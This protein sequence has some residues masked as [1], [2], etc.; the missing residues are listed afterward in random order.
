MKS[1]QLLGYLG[2]LPFITCLYLSIIT[3]E[4]VIAAQQAFI[5]YSAIIL[6]FIAGSIWRED[7]NNTDLKQRIISNIFS[8][9]AFVTLLIERDIALIILAFSFLMLFFYE[10]NLA[11]LNKEKHREVEYMT[12]R[13]WLTLIVI[14][15]HSTAYFLWFF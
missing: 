10:K 1:W 15:L 9:I 11:L 12:M 3:I 14:A 7:N 4:S 2:L 13:F 6:S 5:A 8:L